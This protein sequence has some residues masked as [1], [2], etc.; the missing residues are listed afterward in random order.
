MLKHLLASL[1]E[2]FKYCDAFKTFHL[3]QFMKSR[4]RTSV[5]FLFFINILN[6]ILFLDLFSSFTLLSIFVIL[7][8]LFAVFFI[9]L[10]KCLFFLV[11]LIEN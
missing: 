9:C 4:A 11:K 5:I 2:E 10:Y 3:T 6:S 8:L 7:Q 1:P